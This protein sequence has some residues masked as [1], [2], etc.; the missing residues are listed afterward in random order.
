MGASLAYFL[1]REGAEGAGKKVVVLEARDVG[2][3]A[4]GRNG[5]RLFFFSYQL[6]YPRTDYS[7][8]DMWDHRRPVRIICI[9]NPSDAVDPG[10]RNTRRS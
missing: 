1:T 8:R 7:S 3:G 2:S 10:Y 5:V 4:S 9:N 6:S